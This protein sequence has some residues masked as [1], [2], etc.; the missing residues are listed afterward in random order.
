M[1]D[2][3][4]QSS[5]ANKGKGKE[6][7]ESGKGSGAV[8]D[9]RAA[10]AL[11]RMNSALK[12]DLAGA[13]PE[14]AAERLKNM[15]VNEMMTGM[16]ISGKNQKDMASYKF[17]STQPVTRFDEKVKKHSDDGPIKQID[18][19]QVSKTPRGLPEGFEWCTIDTTEAE[20]RK[21]VYELLSGHY[22][23]DDEAMFR[24][25]YSDAFIDWALQAPG[26]YKEWQVG[27]RASKSGKLLAFITAIPIDLRVREKILRSAEVNFLC[28]H[29]KLRSKRLA[30]VLIEEITRRCYREGI[31]QAI[32]TAGTV[33][34]TPVATCRY[35]HRALDWTKL[36]EVGFS[37]LPPGS[38]KQRQISKFNVPSSTS[39]PGFRAMKPEDVKQVQVLLA[40]YLRRFKLAPQYNEAEVEHWFIHD[41]EKFPE[42]V[43]WTYVVEDPKT[44]KITDFV[45]FYCLP[46]AVIGNPHH[47]TIK[48]AFLFYY[49]TEAAFKGD[50]VF[51]ERLNSLMADTM[52]KAK[53]VSSSLPCHQHI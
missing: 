42:R 45:S 16:S 9:A 51:K 22:V 48:A 38:T 53:K 44:Q 3:N 37:Q 24:L 41:T 39:T 1:A 18:P 15:S 17:W 5:L 46:S 31:F 35:Y 32:Y 12:A 52:V 10:E 30:P 6:S 47:E 34:P 14:E 26:A 27:V 25:N 21:E 7:G 33:L 11:L 4:D 29:K 2:P 43:V 36:Y 23:E 40:K 13:T 28:V 20:Q 19:E 50:K 8:S 49:A